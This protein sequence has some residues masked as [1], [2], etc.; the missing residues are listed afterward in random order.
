MELREYQKKALEEVKKAFGV[1][2]SST[3]LRNSKN[4]KRV[5]LNMA[6]GAG[7][8]FVF[9][10]LCDYWID[11]NFSQQI[12]C[13]CPDQ[14]LVKQT[15]LELEKIT[16]HS[17]AKI[18]D[19]KNTNINAPFCV[20]TFQTLYSQIKSKNNRIK[21][22]LF[23]F[24]VSL[25]IIDEAHASACN[26]YISI[27]N[28]FR[29]APILGLTATPERLDGKNFL[30][31][32]DD[33]FCDT[34]ESSEIIATPNSNDNEKINIEDF[35]K[36]LDKSYSQDLQLAYGIYDTYIP[37]SGIEST[38]RALI[39]Q[40]FLCNFDYFVTSVIDA[41]IEKAEKKI[42]FKNEGNEK[43]LE[44]FLLKAWLEPN[45]I[46]KAIQLWIEHTNWDG[47]TPS[48][49]ISTIIY[50]SSVEHG[51]R[52]ATAFAERGIG[53]EMIDSRIDKKEREAILDRYR[54]KKTLVLINYS[55]LKEG[56]DVPLTK[57]IFFLRKT[58]SKIIWLQGVGR[59]LRKY[60]DENLLILDAGHHIKDIKENQD[61]SAWHIDAEDPRWAVYG[62]P[63]GK[64][65]C[66]T[67]PHCNFIQKV[68]KSD[69]VDGLEELANFSHKV[70]SKKIRYEIA[71]KQHE[72]YEVDDK[73]L[74]YLV[75]VDCGD[76]KQQYKAVFD[77]LKIQAIE[78]TPEEKHTKIVTLNEPEKAILEEVEMVHIYSSD[79][80]KYVFPEFKEIIDKIVTQLKDEKLPLY[81]VIRKIVCTRYFCKKYLKPGNEPTSNLRYLA[82]VTGNNIQWMKNL[83]LDEHPKHPEIGTFEDLEQYYLSLREKNRK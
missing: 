73:V 14:R 32:S 78:S 82:K 17:G 28:F 44:R 80:E 39:D 64:I 22:Q 74:A 3:Q 63:N 8:T 71:P 81:N 83:F 77:F 13:C 57:C 7:K 6:T 11:V 24:G 61:S 56:I 19:G 31:R 75:G 36:K 54:K 15:L 21:Q 55:M 53:A 69:Y 40:G 79:W 60:Q 76:C 9:A 42:D 72:Y 2:K 27:L 62:K 41:A 45:A 65:V 49:G 50:A 43:R 35:R 18:E 59:G 68:D 16:G 33:L 48:E 66:A 67:C 70:L 58:L 4:S 46:E 5:L 29:E 26:S 1:R 52:L 25:I 30:L 47:E 10:M 20:T 38:T 23:P 12:L 37:A 34:N 51:Y